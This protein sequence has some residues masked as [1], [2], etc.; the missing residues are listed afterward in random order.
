VSVE[1]D[2]VRRC[3]DLIDERIGRATP[4]FGGSDDGIDLDAESGMRAVQRVVEAARSTLPTTRH[5]CH[6]AAVPPHRRTELPTTQRS[7]PARR[8]E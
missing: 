4:L 7:L 8:R 5:R 2:G 1:H 3:R 6:G